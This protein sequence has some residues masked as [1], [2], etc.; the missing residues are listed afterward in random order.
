MAQSHQEYG[1]WQWVRRAERRYAQWLRGIAN[2]VSEIV[3][4]FEPG[5]PAVLPDLQYTLSR[6]AEGI[7]PWARAI[8]AR[9]VQEVAGRDARA[10]FRASR[11]IGKSLRK[12]IYEAPIGH[13]AQQIV[14][15]QVDLIGSIPRQE[16]ER[17]QRLTMQG[18]SGGKRYSE[19]VPE[20]LRTNDVTRNRA[21]LIART[22]TAKAQSSIVQARA[23]SVGADQYTWRSVGDAD[24]RRI[25][26]I[27]NGHVFNWTDPPVAEEGG[28]RHHPGAFPNCRCWAEPIIP[29]P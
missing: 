5:D 1:F 24:V 17:V 20:I 23:L 19:V 25:H 14:N 10:W 27:L 2:H 7:E 3:R 26:K 29:P 8:S 28:Q 21:I 16:G 15:E 13:V 4:A 18:V 22:E 9:M 12:E 11:N 6:Y